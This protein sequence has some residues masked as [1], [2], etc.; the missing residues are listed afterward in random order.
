MRPPGRGGRACRASA[1]GRFAG[2]LRHE[3]LL[4]VAAQPA[5]KRR[6]GHNSPVARKRVLQKP[7]RSVGWGLPDLQ[8]YIGHA[9]Y[10]P[11]AGGFRVSR[12]SFSSKPVTTTAREPSRAPLQVTAAISCESCDL[13]ARSSVWPRTAGAAQIRFHESAGARRSKG[14]RYQSACSRERAGPPSCSRCSGP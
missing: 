14:S 8:A 13:V 2:Q 10:K 1:G 9:I 5:R 7:R 3:N 6:F 4:W 12:V 11:P